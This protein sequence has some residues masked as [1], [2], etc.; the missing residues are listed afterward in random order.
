MSL[1]PAC[2]SCLRYPT[3][4]DG[5]DARY[6][7]GGCAEFPADTP[8]DAYDDVYRGFDPDR[9]PDRDPDCDITKGNGR[10]SPSP[11]AGPGK[12]LPAGDGR[13]PEGL[14]PPSGAVGFGFQPHVQQ[15]RTI[16]LTLHRS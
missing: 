12:H 7:V 2:I 1:N 10:G 3:Y 15:S 13:G 6:S 11:A 16:D 14:P 5:I 8:G 4:C 9:D